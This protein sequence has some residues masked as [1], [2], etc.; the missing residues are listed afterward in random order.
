MQ[1]RAPSRKP[2]CVLA[3]VNLLIHFHPIQGKRDPHGVYVAAPQPQQHW[4]LYSFSSPP[5]VGEGALL[6]DM[7]T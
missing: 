6:Q 4:S 2:E 1:G 5:F 3:L 7:L